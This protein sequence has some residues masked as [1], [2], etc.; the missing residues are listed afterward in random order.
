MVYRNTLKLWTFCL[1]L[2]MH[3]LRVP[4]QLWVCTE[5]CWIVWYSPDFDHLDCNDC[6]SLV[7]SPWMVIDYD[8]V[9]YLFHCTKL[10][11]L[12]MCFCIYCEVIENV[13]EPV[14]G[15]NFYACLSDGHA[16]DLDVQCDLFRE[17]HPSNKVFFQAS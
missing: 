1:Q 7:F 10:G 12:L 5:C 14:N 3:N 6:L 13:F 11:V 17:L 16:Y 8:Y 4:A 15:N 9:F 2:Y